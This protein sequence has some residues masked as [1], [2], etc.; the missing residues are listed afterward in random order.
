M[1][2]FIGL[3]GALAGIACPSREDVTTDRAVS[4]LVPFSGERIVQLGRRTRRSWSID[5][6][7]EHPRDYAVLDALTR[8]ESPWCGW[9]RWRRPR[10]S[11][12][13]SRRRCR[14]R[15]TAAVGTGTSHRT[16]VSIRWIVS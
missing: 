5:W 9:G 8:W 12:L 2:S 3:P 1:T 7:A 4:E 16:R 13:R 6:G 11:S 15:S 10:I 14:P